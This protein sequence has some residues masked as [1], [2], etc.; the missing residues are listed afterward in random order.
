MVFDYG[1]FYFWQTRKYFVKLLEDLDIICTLSTHLSLEE[2][3]QAIV[4][5]QKRNPDL[6]ARTFLQVSHC[7][8]LIL[9]LL[10]IKLLI[11]LAQ[12]SVLQ[13][14]VAQDGKFFG[15]D[16]TSVALHNTFNLPD[17]VT[18]KA[19]ESDSFVV[20]AGQVGVDVTSLSLRK[21]DFICAMC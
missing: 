1:Y 2:L 10:L 3:L 18:S 12:V 14:L 15:R 13:I 11:L 20:K 6:V 8:F 7:S 21:Y 5:F 17:T 19:F 16:S 4:D 9:K